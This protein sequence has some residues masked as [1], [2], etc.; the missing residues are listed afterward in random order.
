MAI[1]DLESIGNYAVRIIFDDTHDT[2]IYSWDYL[3]ELGQRQ[4]ELWK[5]YLQAL[6]EKGLSRDA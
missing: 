4:D 2:G 1:N 5:R 3:Y 6:E